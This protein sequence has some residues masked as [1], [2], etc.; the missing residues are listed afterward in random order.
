M[1]VQLVEC[2]AAPE[3][4]ASSHVRDAEDLHERTT[5]DEVLFDL[6]VGDP[7]GVEPP[8]GDVVLGD[9]RSDSTRALTA[10]F[11]RS[12]RGAPFIG[13]AR[14]NGASVAPCVRTWSASALA[15]SVWVVISSR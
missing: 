12:A 5:D 10:S 8:G 7:R 13:L 1:D 3:G 15:S 2:R 14:T 6:M 4:K 11:Q 9:H